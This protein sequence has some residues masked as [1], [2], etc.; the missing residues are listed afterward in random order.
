M[1]ERHVK[2]PGILHRL[3][4]FTVAIKLKYTVSP[5]LYDMKFHGLAGN[6]PLMPDT[7]DSFQ[8]LVQESSPS[9]MRA[10]STNFKSLFCL[11][12]ISNTIADLAISSSVVGLLCA[13]R[14]A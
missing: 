12:S 8:A 13:S 7:P 4:N 3:N 2:Y 14:I 5:R 10:L 6:S 11:I 1:L 9:I